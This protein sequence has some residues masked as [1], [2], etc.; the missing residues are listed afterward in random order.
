MARQSSSDVDDLFGFVAG[1][2]VVAAALYF[3]LFLLLALPVIYLAWRLYRHMADKLRTPAETK[4][5]QE[6]LRLKREALALYNASFLP[7]TSPN[8]RVV[9]MMQE[10]MRDAEEPLPALPVL[11]AFCEVMEELMRDEGWWDVPECDEAYELPLESAIYLRNYLRRQKRLFADAPALFD[12]WSTKLI[13]IATGMMAYLP[14][15]IAEDEIEEKRHELRAPLVDLA[16]EPAEMIE[17]LIMTFF[18]EDVEKASLFEDLQERL[19][20]NALRASGIDPTERHRTHK[21]ITLPTDMRHKTPTELVELYLAGTPF[22]RFLLSEF[23]FSIPA[24]TRFEHCHILGGTGHGKTQLLQQLIHHDLMQV[25]EGRASLIVIDSQGDLIRKLSHLAYFDPQVERSLADRFMLID[26]N[27]VE[28]PAGLNMFD[29]NL[30]RLQ[31]YSAVER[32]KILNGTI[33][34]YEYIFGALLGAE[35]TQKQGVIFRYLARLMLTI[36]N[37]T[38]Q[39][40][41]ELMED[42]RPFKPYMEQLEGTSRRFFETQFF[43]RSFAGTKTQIL[44]RLWGVLSNTTFERMFSNP[45]NKVDLFGAMN[46][47]KVILINTAKDLLKQEGCEIF[48]R[49]SIAMIAQAALQRSVMPEDERTPTYVFVDEAHDYLDEHSEVLFNQARKYRVALHIAHQNLGQL[50][51]GL[52]ASIMASTSIK[53]AGGMS[54]KDAGVMARE[55]QCEP[56]FLRSMKKRRRHTEFACWIKNTTPQPLR[57]AVPLGFLE[58]LPRLQDAAHERLIAENRKRYCVSREQLDKALALTPA[59]A[60]PATQEARPSSEPVA[61]EKERRS[62]PET[63]ASEEVPALEDEIPARQRP[64]PPKRQTEAPSPMGGGG[65]AHQYL[66]QLVMRVGQEQG[67]RTVVEYE[68]LD[69]AGR[70][71]VAL[72]QGD[73]RIAFEISVSSPPEQELHNAEKCL[74]AGFDQVVVVSADPKH[75][76]AIRSH[77]LA[78]LDEAHHDRMHFLSPEAVLAHIEE[79]AAQTASS[80]ETIRGYRVKVKH[81][82]V[83]PE[84]RAA[85]RQALAGVIR[86]SLKHLRADAD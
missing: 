43:D 22:E 83:S 39:T 46:S 72:E 5:H 58:G 34:L 56:Q 54:A 13:S 61:S 27:D 80:E 86:R 11:V 9:Q 79:L 42:G 6:T 51:A 7:K 8:D 19:D 70:V 47:G 24:P 29:V 59:A 49:F 33:E 38:V 66:Q 21:K 52:E 64:T 41:R 48:G 18:D 14:A 4:E 60:E 31:S 30:E 50:S 17:R 36:P 74:A 32:E 81:K 37:A 45:R 76:N 1:A 12:I 44:R 78:H 15:R 3:S 63:S 77:L 85:R 65:K 23:P 69:G 55:M 67:F 68:V 35:L 25:R 62:T 73:R 84:E 20:V 16:E 75:L 82:A 10:A 2:I 57:L 53:L 26:P 71:D 28:H 40:L